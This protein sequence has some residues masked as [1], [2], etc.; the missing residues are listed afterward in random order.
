M[1]ALR[2]NGGGLCRVVTPGSSSPLPSARRRV[3]LRRVGGVGCRIVG[4]CAAH[5][6]VGDLGPP[7][8]SAV[9]RGSGRPRSARRQGAGSSWRL[10]GLRASGRSGPDRGRTPHRIPAL[11]KR[12]L[13][14]RR[15]PHYRPSTP[16]TG[17]LADAPESLDLGDHESAVRHAN[18]SPPA[19]GGRPLYGAPGASVE[20]LDH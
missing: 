13:R 12:L 18:G 16:D 9:R 19:P 14:D 2:G 11:T 6:T 1:V 7:C 4:G 17:W 5:F 3:V 10:G 8:R 20:L 15:S